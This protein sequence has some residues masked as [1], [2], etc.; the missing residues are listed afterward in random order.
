MKRKIT[1]YLIEKLIEKEVVPQ[2]EK[3]LYQ[4]GLSVGITIIQNILYTL[5]LGVI[6]GNVIETVTFL[7]FYIILRSYAGGYHAKTEKK[8]FRYSIALVVVVEII[9]VI[10][11]YGRQKIS[12]MLIL[13]ISS[14]IILCF[15]PLES[16]N[17]PITENER[18]NYR[19][20]TVTVLLIGIVILF[21]SHKLAME[22]IGKGVMMGIVIEA[23]LLS[24]GAIERK[25]NIKKNVFS[26]NVISHQ[27]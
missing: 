23:I 6:F 10:M 9:F 12:E 24:V 1:E 16:I 2:H 7:C 4:Y 17:K 8:C 15:S 20:I 14:V 19:K 11:Q 18:K 27:K 21:L 26:K 22:E 13:A 5:F 25:S 3:E